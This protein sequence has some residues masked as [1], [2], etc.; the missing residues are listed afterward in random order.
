ML[1]ISLAET[2]WVTWL[3][4][5]CQ[6]G[7]SAFRSRQLFLIGV[8]EAVETTFSAETPFQACV[9]ATAGLE[10]DSSFRQLSGFLRQ[11]QQKWSLIPA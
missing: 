8:L 7:S 5:I 2:A 11:I 9:A 1:K 10:F 3:P 4:S 6:A